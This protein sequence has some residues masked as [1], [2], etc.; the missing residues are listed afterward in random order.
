MQIGELGLKQLVKMGVAGD[1]AGAATAGAERAYGLDHRIEHDRVLAHPEVVVRA[2][3]R[4]LGVDAMIEGARKLAATPLEMGEGAVAPFRATLI[5][6]LFKEAF[7]I[8][9]VAS[10]FAVDVHRAG[11]ATLGAVWA[12]VFPGPAVVF[13]AF[14]VSQRPRA[15]RRLRPPSHRRLPDD[16]GMSLGSALM[17][18]LVR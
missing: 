1:V 17:A 14:A 12:Q 4:H 11:A 8:H 6:T 16:A 13:T 18:H 3:H 7:V 9:L 10:V 2:P 15:K 5:K